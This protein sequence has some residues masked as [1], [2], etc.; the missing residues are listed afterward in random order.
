MS[1]MLKKN[2]KEKKVTKKKK[3]KEPEPEEAE[4]ELEQEEEVETKDQQ[5]IDEESEDDLDSEPTARVIRKKWK[6]VDVPTQTAPVLYN[7]ETKEQ[8]DLFKG[9][10]RILN[11]LEEE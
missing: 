2:T 7:T 11:I 8:L 10:A 4:E 1:W 9:I 6:V 5:V 3:V